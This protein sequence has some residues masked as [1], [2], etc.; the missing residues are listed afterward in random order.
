MDEQ[1]KIVDAIHAHTQWFVRLRLAIDKASSEFNPEAVKADNNCAFGKWLYGPTLSAEDGGF[2]QVASLEPDLA[3][4]GRPQESQ[5]RH[6]TNGEPGGFPRDKKS[7]KALFPSPLTGHGK[8]DKEIGQGTIG[9][10]CLFPIEHI[11]SSLFH[12]R[13]ADPLRVAAGPRL[14]K[15]N[16]GRPSAGGHPGQDFFFLFAVCGACDEYLS[17]DQMDHPGKGK[18]GPAASRDEGL[19]G[20]KDVGKAGPFSPERGRDAPAQKA[21]SGHRP[22]ETPGDPQVRGIASRGEVPACK[23]QRLHRQS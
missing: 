21:T 12:S 10:P 14:G 3:V 6:F 15:G 23:A 17:D 19:H 2:G 20:R 1:G 22:P 8:Y 18:P 7:R 11:G 13:R 9:E 16:R 5:G 4:R